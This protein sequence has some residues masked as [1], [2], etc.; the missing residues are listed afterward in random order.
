MQHYF[1]VWKQMIETINIIIDKNEFL[2]KRI[3][4]W[5]PN[6]V[7]QEKSSK[8]Q[9]KNLDLKSIQALGEPNHL[10]THST[11]HRILLDVELRQPIIPKSL[12]LHQP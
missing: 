12:P 5:V 6:Y 10:R 9:L 2:P 4:Q 7:D 1:L 11:K 3:D 8:K